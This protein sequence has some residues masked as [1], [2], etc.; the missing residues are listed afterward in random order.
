LVLVS[1]QVTALRLHRRQ[2]LLLLLLWRLLLRLD[3]LDYGLLNYRHHLFQHLFRHHF[4]G[5]ILLF[6]FGQI[7]VFGPPGAHA[8]RQGV[9]EHELAIVMD[10]AGAFG[11]VDGLLIIELFLDLLNGL[12]VAGGASYCI[13]M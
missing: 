3:L 12:L 4:L 10:G 6:G 9:P 5:S 8:E 2:E 13:F 7:D 11:D 1:F